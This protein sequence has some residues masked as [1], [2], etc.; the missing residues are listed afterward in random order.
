MGLN[1]ILENEDGT[2]IESA[3]DERS[4]L[5]NLLRFV[6]AHE[7]MLLA[8]VD[9]YGDTVFN[10]LQMRQFL[11][12]WGVVSEHAFTPE[13]KVLVAEVRVLAERCQAG[14]H[15]YIRFVGD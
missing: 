14:V 4:S 5:L 1:V 13:D 8:F 2:S 3:Y 11:T 6:R 15:L 9:P 12:E 10:R 7:H